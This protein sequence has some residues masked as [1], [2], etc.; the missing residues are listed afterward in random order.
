MYGIPLSLSMSVTTTN[1]LE[2]SNE[3]IDHRYSTTAEVGASA[4]YVGVKAGVSQTH[5]YYEEIIL[6]Q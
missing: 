1:T 5:S 3:G 2:I 4:C 6:A